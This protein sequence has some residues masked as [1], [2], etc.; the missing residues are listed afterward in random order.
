MRMEK[1]DY[2]NSLNSLTNDYKSNDYKQLLNLINYHYAYVSKHRQMITHCRSRCRK[3]ER[4]KENDVRR[5]KTSDF[6]RW[7]LGEAYNNVEE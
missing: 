7:L 2:I 5:Y 1:A 3:L 6:M 4:S